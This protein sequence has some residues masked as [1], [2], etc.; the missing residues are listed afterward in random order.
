MSDIIQ[1]LP[2]HVANQIA[3]GEVV[4]RPSSVVKELLENSVDAGASY[5]QLIIKD[6]GKTLIQVIDNG[7][8]MSETDARLCFERHATSKIKSAEDLFNLN[9]KGF[10][11]EAMASIAA[12]AQVE[13]KTK[14]ED[15]ELGTVIKIEGGKIISQEITQT[16]TGTNTAVKNL[17][18]NIPARRNFLKTD[19]IETRHIMEEFE[20]VALVHPNIAFSLHHNNT[21]VFNLLKGN[22]KQRIVAIFG[23][24]TNERLI[25]INEDTEPLAI[26]GFL[27][28][29]DFAKKKRGEQ[30]FFVNGRYIKSPYLH[31]AINAAFDG[32]IDKSNFPGYFLY[33]TV[34]TE[35]IDINIHPT[36]T[37]VKFDNETV[38]YEI[39]RASVKH[40]LGQFNIAP[41]LDFTKNPDLETPY[42][43]ASKPIGNTPTITV[44]RTFNPFQQESS[45]NPFQ[46]NQSTRKFQSNNDYSQQNSWEVLYNSIENINTES[47]FSTHS[48]DVEILESP[49]LFEKNQ[50]IEIHNTLQLN[51]KYLL[52]TIQTGTVLVH[53]N[54]AHQRVLYEQFLANIT[55]KEASSQQLLFPIT[56]HLSKKE[57]LVIENLYEEL[58]STGFRFDT[59]TEQEVNIIG[60]PTTISE[61]QINIVFEQ[62]IQDF[63]DEIIAQSFSQL[64][65]IAKSLSKSLA[66]KT[67]Q[68]LNQTEQEQLIF[69]LFL[70]KEPKNSPFGKKVYT[71]IDVKKLDSIFNAF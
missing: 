1:L 40:S 16:P 7:S 48:V 24:K 25:P 8:G 3:A 55:V 23:H 17:F 2:D 27:V 26:H 5:I 22:L 58:I 66:I 39:L 43:Y 13:M 15:Q 63:Q 54:L 37:E 9:T 41:T 51:N 60:I 56:I 42:E 19:N 6:A 46:S 71:F 70:C 61:S 67:G 57:I 32:L 29:P 21:E 34:P 64:D 68:K 28:K 62:L 18:Y 30:Y 20:R 53:Q 12:I 50:E 10:R 36:K 52:C 11:G 69:D 14:K 59:I 45:Y 49:T 38:L 4:Q 35:S 44:D 47:N 33:L 65:M 31:H